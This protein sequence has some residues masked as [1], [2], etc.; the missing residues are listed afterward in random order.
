MSFTDRPTLGESIL[1]HVR[2][3]RSRIPL[4]P[5]DFVK[6]FVSDPK[7]SRPAGAVALDFICDTHGVLLMRVWM[8]P[9]SGEITFGGEGVKG[10]WDNDPGGRGAVVLR[11]N[12]SDCLH[13]AV[14]T[15]DWL[16]ATFARVRGDFEAGK[17][18]PIASFSLSQVGTSG[19]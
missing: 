2:G 16:V 15:N 6:D 5:A 13:S 18:L 17:G 9:R 14:L 19:V 7:M 12:R 4:R 11:C 3:V 10:A 8:S 1:A